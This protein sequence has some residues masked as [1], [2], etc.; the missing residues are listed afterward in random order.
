M[1][2]CNASLYTERRKKA[3]KIRQ[4]WIISRSK[5]VRLRSITARFRPGPASIIRI[6][7]SNMG[8]TGKK[9]D[10]PRKESGAPL[11]PPPAPIEDDDVEDGDFATPKRD[12]NGNDDE[13]L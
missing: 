11:K 1:A 6:E 12:R 8:G 13:P 7:E 4:Q 3:G 10:P 9:N 2:P 5:T